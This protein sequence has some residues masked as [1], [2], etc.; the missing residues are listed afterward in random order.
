M[1]KHKK[2]IQNNKFKLSAPTWNYEFE[3]PDGSYFVSD[4]QDYVEY[5]SK[6]N[7]GK[8]LLNHQYKYM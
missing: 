3:L 1:E 8:I 6:K 7:M 4:I 5:I 2:L